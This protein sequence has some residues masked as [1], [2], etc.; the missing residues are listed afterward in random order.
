MKLLHFAFDEAEEAIIFIDADRKVFLANQ[1]SALLLNQEE[2][3]QM[4]SRP[5]SDLM[6]L[7]S[8]NGESADANNLLISQSKL[9]DIRGEG[10]YCISLPSGK[11]TDFKSVYWRT[12]DLINDKFLMITVTEPSFE[13]QNLFQQEKFMTNLTH[14]LRTP[15][16]IVA[17]NLQRL[18]RFKEISGCASTNLT[19][20]QEEVSR[21]T[22]LLENL[23]LMTSLEIDPALLGIKDQLLVPLLRRWNEKSD[24]QSLKIV[25]LDPQINPI[26]RT[27]ANALLLVLDLLFDNARRHGMDS[28]PI[29]LHLS[30]REYPPSCVI[31]LVSSGLAPPVDPN[32]VKRWFNPFVRGKESDGKQ[33]EGTG[34]GLSLARQLTKSWGGDLELFQEIENGF[35]VTRAKFTIPFYLHS[36]EGRGVSQIDWV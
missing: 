29:E 24:N 33:V 6:Q 20:A 10:S 1:A 21:I 4:I 9:S 28:S 14:E 23:S 15:L 36:E 34:L 19:I 13:H 26:V 30:K 35:T 16:A 5:L 8:Q 18:S 22:R 3:I 12:V 31:E 11:I 17:G 25:F 2:S 27:D 7:C 32:E